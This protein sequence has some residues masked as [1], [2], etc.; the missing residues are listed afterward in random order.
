MLKLNM[1]PPMVYVTAKYG[2]GDI[3]KRFDLVLYKM[4]DICTNLLIKAHILFNKLH[5]NALGL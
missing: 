2:N 5:G 3:Y 1:V 4:W